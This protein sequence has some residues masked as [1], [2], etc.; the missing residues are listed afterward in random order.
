MRLMNQ[1]GD[2]ARH[3]IVSG[4]PDQLSAR[5]AIAPGISYEIAQ[6][7]P[8]LR[9]NPSV[10]RY[11]AIARYMRRFDLVLSYN[12]GAIDGVMAR[13]VFSKRMPP[14]VH[15]HEG[16]VQRRRGERVERS[17]AISIAAS[18]SCGSARA[19]VVP[20]QTL[21]QIALRNWKQLAGAPPPHLVNG[22]ATAAYAAK[23]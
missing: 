13:R 15:H 23:T 7:P 20:S 4:I 8:P 1:F 5:D 12:W 22:I 18:R 19:L 14:L 2:R 9:G 16:R 21:E 3:T 11:E 6:D 10:A 17:S